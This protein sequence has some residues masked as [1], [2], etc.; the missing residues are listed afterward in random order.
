MGCWGVND[1]D[2][3]FFCSFSF[4]V[5]F[6]FPWILSYLISLTSVDRVKSDRVEAF[7]KFIGHL[8]YVLYLVSSPCLLYG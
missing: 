7:P 1:S 8:A 3:F 6:F 5:L 2:V 4:P